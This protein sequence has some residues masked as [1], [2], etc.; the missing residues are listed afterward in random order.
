M[1]KRILWVTDPWE[2]LDHPRD[3]S[4][5]LAEETLT[6]GHLPFW[7]SHHSLR[8][9][10]GEIQL[11]ARKVDGVFPGRAQESF[12]LSEN[13]A[14]RP[15]DFDVIVYRTDP[16]VDHAYIYPL[17][18]IADDCRGTKTE[19]VNPAEILALESEKLLAVALPDLFPTSVVASD[20]EHLRKF[21]FALGK[22]V[23]KPLHQAQ[24][25]GIELLD[26]SNEENIREKLQLATHDFT[27]PVLLQAYL[28]GIAQGETRLWFVDG[29]LLAHARKLPLEGDFRV[30]IDR[31]SSLVQAELTKKEKKA[32]TQIGALLKK[33]KI[34]LAAIDLIEGLVT[35][36]NFTSPG[37]ITQ[38]EGLL[39]ENLAQT[40]VTALV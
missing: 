3:T 11:D 27:T 18:L 39:G 7:A 15:S 30:N 25:K 29:K 20:W 23:L 17:Q 16:P 21:V 32:S 13:E 9:E 38:M 14:A 10:D 5:R 33:R 4:L 6:L 35:D 37:L 28:P 40:I 22:A 19:I 1:K 2:T 31:G 36:S 34:R 8:I 12:T 24:S 26:S